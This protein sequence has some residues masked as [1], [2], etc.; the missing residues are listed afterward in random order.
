MPTATTSREA[1]ES[2]KPITASQRRLVCEF[3]ARQ[4]AR[5]ATDEEIA[6]GTGLPSN[7]VR[8]R[9]GEVF[10]FGLITAA[11]GE[12]RATKSGRAAVC[13]HVTALGLKACGV[14]GWCAP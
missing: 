11:L 4:G 1:Y 14:E 6:D 12:R 10:G 8:P 9:R 2:I 5:G 3:I 13:W 7:S